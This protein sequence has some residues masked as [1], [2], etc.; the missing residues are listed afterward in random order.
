MET[1]KLLVKA[2]LPIFG[3][4][5]IAVIAFVVFNYFP[6]SE[7]SEDNDIQILIGFWLSLM[8]IVLAFLMMKSD[9]TNKD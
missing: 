9:K 5:A 2:F 1:L 6:D 4:V 7:Q 3:L 8:P